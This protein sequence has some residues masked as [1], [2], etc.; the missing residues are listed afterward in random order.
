MRERRNQIGATE[1]TKEGTATPPSMGSSAEGALLAQVLLKSNERKRGE[2]GFG[3][4]PDGNSK[5]VNNII[6]QRRELRKAPVGK[7]TLNPW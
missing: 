7:I 3:P 5:I 1:K 6:K 4:V 2:N